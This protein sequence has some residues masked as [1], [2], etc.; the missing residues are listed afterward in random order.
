MAAEASAGVQVQT[1]SSRTRRSRYV[2][3]AVLLAIALGGAAMGWKLLRHGGTEFRTGNM[4]LKQLTD[5]GQ[6]SLYAAI[7]ADGHTLAYVKREGDRSLR[8][9]QIVTGSEVTVVPAGPGFFDSATFSPDGNYLYY[10]HSDPGNAINTNLY[11]VPSMG[12]APRQVVTD[13]A[14]GV[15]FSVDGKRMAYVRELID[16]RISQVLV[17]NVDGSGEKLLYQGAEGA[18]FY[19]LSWGGP[20]DRLALLSKVAGKN[21]EVLILGADG[22]IERTL[23]PLSIAFDVAWTPDGSG[24]F[25]VGHAKTNEPLQIWFQPYPSGPVIKVSND[26]NDYSGLGVTGDGKV[27]VT[28][29]YHVDSA[30]YVGDVPH[31]LGDKIDWKLAVISG[32][33]TAGTNGLSWTSSGKLLQLDGAGRLFI[34]DAQGVGRTQLADENQGVLEVDACRDNDL[35]LESRMGADETSTVWKLNAATGETAELSNAKSAG[36]LSCTPDGKSFVY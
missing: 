26:L 31:E 10:A 19:G 29:R 25:L 2:P 6:A 1:A 12:G 33:Q 35:I 23:Q 21:T 27:L 13:V 17:A 24:L 7:S 20:D 8:V 9:K 11:V 18:T 5:H 15:S 36:S 14:G 32:E 4:E 16:K 34:T 3:I 28:S 22:K 30:I